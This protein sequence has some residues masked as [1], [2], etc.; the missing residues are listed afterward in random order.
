MSYSRSSAASYLAVQF[1]T[2]CTETGQ[3]TSDTA[4]GFGP[5]LDNALRRLGGVAEAGLSS[6]TL[7]DE[8]VPA[9]LALAE[10]YALVRF[11]RALATRVDTGITAVEGNRE[12]L[13]AH[14][15]K[16]IALAATDCS[17]QGYPVDGA[18]TWSSARLQLDYIEPEPA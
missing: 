6:A 10:Y 15:Q 14:V 9:F 17:A 8:D 2:L 13:F 4:S 12:Q 11:A 1:A 7:A 18:Q 5:A 3:A 16:L